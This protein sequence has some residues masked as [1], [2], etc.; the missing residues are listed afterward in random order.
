MSQAVRSW[1]RSCQ[2]TG[3]EKQTS[4]RNQSSGYTS[5]ITRTVKRY[6]PKVMWQFGNEQCY[7]KGKFVGQPNHHV[8]LVKSLFTEHRIKQ[9]R[10]AI[11]KIPM[12]R[13][14][15]LWSSS[16]REGCKSQDFLCNQVLESLHS[17][18]H[19][20]FLVLIIINNG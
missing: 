4:D 17:L 11:E 10:F 8:T 6:F 13:P 12:S 9:V 19:L 1:Q 5:R 2:T 18:F 14:F 15:I 3:L 16:I 7:Q 20:P